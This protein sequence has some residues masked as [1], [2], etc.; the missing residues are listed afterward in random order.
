MSPTQTSSSSS[1]EE[2]EEQEEQEQEQEEEEERHRENV[3]TPSVQPIHP[4]NPP[5]N[6]PITTTTAN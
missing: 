6:Q 1:E 3:A 5:T 2:E 4:T